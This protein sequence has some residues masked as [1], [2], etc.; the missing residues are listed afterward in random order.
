MISEDPLK[1]S[2]Q[3]SFAL[4]ISVSTL[5]EVPYTSSS[6]YDELGAAN[7]ERADPE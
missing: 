2:S 3:R 5:T 7:D 6:C 1:A 4:V